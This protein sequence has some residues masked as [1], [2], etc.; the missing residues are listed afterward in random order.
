MFLPW[1]HSLTHSTQSSVLNYSWQTK[2]DWANL[3]DTFLALPYLNKVFGNINHSVLKTFFLVSTH[4]PL[5]VSSFHPNFSQHSS[6]VFFPLNFFFFL[7]NW[8]PHSIWIP[9]VISSTFMVLSAYTFITQIM[10]SKSILL[11]WTLNEIAKD[12]IRH[13]SKAEFMSTLV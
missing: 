5:L 7:A 11:S 2:N 9:W 12:F 13:V 3:I 10:D 8:S 1:I 6:T 4:H